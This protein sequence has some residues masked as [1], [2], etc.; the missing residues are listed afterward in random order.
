MPRVPHGDLI[1]NIS[2]PVHNYLLL[3]RVILLQSGY[4]LGHVFSSYPGHPVIAC[5]NVQLAL[6]LNYIAKHELPAPVL[7]P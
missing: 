4:S 5:V 3:P 7:G 1:N 6:S 2:Q